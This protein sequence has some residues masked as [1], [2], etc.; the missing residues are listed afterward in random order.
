MPTDPDLT[1]Q[2]DAWGQ[3][4]R[5]RLVAPPEPFIRQVRAARGPQAGRRVVLR[6]IQGLA[7]AA[8][9]ALVASVAFWPA[10]SSKPQD[11]PVVRSTREETPTTLAG[12]TR[13]AVETDTLDWLLES[14]PPPAAAPAAPARAADAYCAGCIDELTKL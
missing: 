8:A 2:L 12:M 11:T 10:P 1:A 4:E 13:R 14:A 5:S 3:S 6:I 7:L 9:V